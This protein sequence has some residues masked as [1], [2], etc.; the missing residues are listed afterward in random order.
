MSTVDPEDV[1]RRV[2]AASTRIVARY[3]YAEAKKIAEQVSDPAARWEILTTALLRVGW[4][5]RSNEHA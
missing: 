3:W 4:P 1:G 2:A 5:K